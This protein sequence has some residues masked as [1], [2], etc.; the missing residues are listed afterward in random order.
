MDKPELSWV[1][2]C[3]EKGKYEW[4]F[5]F[6]RDNPNVRYSQLNPVPFTKELSDEAAMVEIKKLMTDNLPVECTWIL[7]DTAS[8]WKK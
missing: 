1:I 3:T 5:M 4:S 7:R 2:I 6:F 8:R